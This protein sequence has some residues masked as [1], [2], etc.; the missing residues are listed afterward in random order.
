M[1][2]KTGQIAPN[3]EVADIFGNKINLHSLSSHKIILTF[4]RY[5][6][7]AL[8]NL[9]ISEI[10]SASKKMHELDIQLIAIFQS[11]K[12]S[13]IKSIFDR[14]TFD[15]T[16]ISDTELKLYN[17]YNVKPSWIKLVR[18]MS[19]KGIKEMVKASSKGYKLGGKVE[20]KFHQIPADFL[21][22]KNKEIELA[23]Y[24]TNLVDHLSLATV[25]K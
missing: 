6:E 21:I 9:R 16:I 10:K 5:A 20:G 23:H 1:K 14:H 3:F 19:W 12:E 2:V 8:C 7:C 4:F 13:L 15:F 11:S 18:T 17:L 24:G 22:N 25:L